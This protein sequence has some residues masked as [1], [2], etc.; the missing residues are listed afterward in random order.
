ML[1]LLEIH[2]LQLVVGGGLG[3]LVTGPFY[4]D[5]QPIMG[6]V[7]V[8]E[9]LPLQTD[10][11]QEGQAVAAQQAQ[12]AQPIQVAVVVDTAHQEPLDRGDQAL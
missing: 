4:Q 2:H 7:V 5:Q 12:M 10:L 1:E 3:A 9:I 8:P 11:L 6:V